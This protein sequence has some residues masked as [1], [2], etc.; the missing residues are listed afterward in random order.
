MSEK[1][2]ERKRAILINVAILVSLIGVTSKA[3]R[4]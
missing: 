3:I 1:I 4:R 2:T